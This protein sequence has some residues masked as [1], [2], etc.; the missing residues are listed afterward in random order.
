MRDFT[1]F[2]YIIVEVA[3]IFSGGRMA[4]RKSL[5]VQA[6]LVSRG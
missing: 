4:I 5:Q 2:A 3:E 1:L 6:L